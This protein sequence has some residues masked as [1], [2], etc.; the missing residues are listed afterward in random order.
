MNQ[1]QTELVLKAMAA[2]WPGE[3][4]D[5]RIVAWIDTLRDMLPAHAREAIRNL[6]R[7]KTFLP[8][9]AEFFEA[10]DAIKHRESLEHEE[11][12]LAEPGGSVCECGGNGWVEVDRIGQGH[13]ERCPR[14]N[15]EPARRD[16]EGNPIEHKAGCTCGR[17]HYGP[18]RYAIIQ[19]GRD[20]MGPRRKSP[21]EN[22]DVPSPDPRYEQVQ[23]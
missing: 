5:D 2:T 23:F 1:E 16:E 11:R 21:V 10:V 13:V 3:I 14:C 20:G 6:K 7:V 17:C 9:H 12:M 19:T 15:A 22:E 18:K 8:S 4:T